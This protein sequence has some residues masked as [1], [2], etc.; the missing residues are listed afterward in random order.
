MMPGVSSEQS[1][2]DDADETTA[3]AG[4]AWRRLVETYLSRR[5]LVD[6]VARS[7][8]LTAGDLRTL[9]VLEPGVPRAHRTISEIL[10]RDPANVTWLVNRL[11]AKGYVEREKHVRDRRVRMVALTTAGERAQ[12]KVRAGLSVPPPEF[13]RMDPDDLRTLIT[14]LE[15]IDPPPY[16][17]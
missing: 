14:L 7:V 6:D 15:R 13:E 9:F 16:W 2:D 10:H 1:N 12:E 8:N 4:A 5:Y 17:P 3:L 11:E